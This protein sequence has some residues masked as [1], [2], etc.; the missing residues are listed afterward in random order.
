MKS[1]SSACAMRI[2]R[3]CGV[4]T[5]WR[6]IASRSAGAAADKIA[7]VI[8]SFGE[9][10]FDPTRVAARPKDDASFTLICH[11]TIEPNYGLDLVVRAVSI[12]KDRIP[13]LRL[14]VWGGGTQ[15]PALEAL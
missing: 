7:V 11:G 6:C 13:G 3:W 14:D 12:L 1:T 10:R 15:L 8:N 2:S 9:E 4:P 5:A